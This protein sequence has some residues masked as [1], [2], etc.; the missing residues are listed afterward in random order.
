MGAPD[1]LVVRDVVARNPVAR[2]ISRQ[3]ITAATRDFSIQVH[4]LDDGED[5]RVDLSAAARVLAVACRVAA[6][7]A[8]RTQRPEDRDTPALRVMTGGMSAIA[9]CSERGWRWRRLDAV[10]VDQALHEAM[11]L[12]RGAS[13]RELRDAWAY[14][15][16][17]R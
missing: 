11:S 4:L 13:T 2:A 14:V 7:R 9:Q 8:D 6:L 1:F 5:V 3:R 12:V 16:A 15:E 17:M 10:A